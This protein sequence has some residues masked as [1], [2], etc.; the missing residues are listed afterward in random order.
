L[1]LDGRSYTIPGCGGTA[2]SVVISE[3]VLIRLQATGGSSLSDGVARSGVDR[4]DTTARRG[5]GTVINSLLFGSRFVTIWLAMGLLLL[6]CQIV[7]PETLSSASWSVLLP[8][9]SV[10]AVVALGQMLVIMMG[11]IDLSMAATISLLANILVGVSKGQNDNLAY[12]I[13]IVLMW[14]VV[15]GLVNGILVSLLE[16]NPLIVTL[17]TGLILLGIADEYRVGTANN[18]TVPKVLSDVVFEKWFGISKVFWGVLVLMLLVS[19]VLRATPGGRRFQAVGANRR[20][21][22]MAGIRVRLYVIFAYVMC[23]IAGGIAGILLGGI[24]VSPGV[25]VGAPYLLGPVAAVVLGG[26]ALSGGLA[27]PVSTW[28]AAFF[29]EILTQML[30]VLGLS[31]ASQYVVFGLAIIFGMLISGD[32]I[33]DFVGRL[34]LRPGLRRFVAS[35]QKG[36]L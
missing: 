26:A 19:L 33:A 29:V 30:R 6:V 12:A 14:A 24:V 31:N 2:G 1:T 17:S 8:I 7:A 21:A 5:I 11:G 36:E 23:S 34:L 10:I 20:A 18:S 3:H 27:S 9:G 32:R 22:W 28:V 35:G 15:I 4:V 25:D 16:L 13:F